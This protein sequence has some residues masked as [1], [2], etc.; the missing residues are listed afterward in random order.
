MKKV[1]SQ[2][3]SNPTSISQYAALAALNGDQSCIDTMVTAFKQRHDYLVEALNAIDGIRCVAG[4]GTFYTFANIS[5]LMRKA[6]VNTDVELCEK[7]LNDAGVAL[8]PG[9]AFGTDEHCRLSFATDL[10]TLKE[11]V[12]RIRK[13]ADQL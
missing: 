9:S 3:T 4:D 13:F 7:L 11:A 5:Q 1:Q 6:G 12:A 8:V 2:S 10:N